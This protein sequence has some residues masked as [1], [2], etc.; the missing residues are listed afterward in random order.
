MAEDESL[1]EYCDRTRAAADAS[2]DSS[3]ER[4][5]PLGDDTTSSSSA[6]FGVSRG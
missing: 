1:L 5:S 2:R 6:Q 4:E 3:I